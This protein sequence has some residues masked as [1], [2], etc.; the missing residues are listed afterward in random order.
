VLRPGEFVRSRPI[1][2]AGQGN[3]PGQLIGCL[4]LTP[5]RSHQPEFLDSTRPMPVVK[6]M[7]EEWSPSDKQPTKS[8]SC[9]SV[10]FVKAPTHDATSPKMTIRSACIG[11]GIKRDVGFDEP[12]VNPHLHAHTEP[13]APGVGAQTN[14]FLES[15]RSDATSTQYSPNFIVL[16]I[17]T[18]IA[19]AAAVAARAAVANERSRSIHRSRPYL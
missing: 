2:L 3:L 5:G 18:A 11:G 19:K 1:F 17:A 12:F 10:R 8:C 9:A 6:P 16:S 14:D 4:N 13:T 7:V 15:L